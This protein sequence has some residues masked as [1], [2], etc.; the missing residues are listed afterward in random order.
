MTD[1]LSRE[2]KAR[3]DYV[4]VADAATLAEL[5]RVTGPALAL[6]R[7]WHRPHAADRQHAARLGRGVGHATA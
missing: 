6:D 1:V 7:R 4:S 2:P 3:V 5:Q